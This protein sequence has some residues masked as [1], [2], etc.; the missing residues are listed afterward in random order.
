MAEFGLFL[1][2]IGVGVLATLSA[3]VV[4]V[5]AAVSWAVSYTTI[6]RLHYQIAQAETRERRA[7][8][9]EQASGRG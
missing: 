6:A 8:E 3:A 9:Y 1:A 2:G 7:R 5:V 4:S